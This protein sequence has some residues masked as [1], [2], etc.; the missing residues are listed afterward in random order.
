MRGTHA[1]CLPPE[2]GV[3][4]ASQETT[5]SPRVGFASTETEA[6]DGWVVANYASAGVHSHASWLYGQLFVPTHVYVARLR[7]EA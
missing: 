3:S 2:E 7:A 4:L 1:R 6:T 5:L